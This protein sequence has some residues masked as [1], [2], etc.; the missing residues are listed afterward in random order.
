[1]GRKRPP[2]AVAAIVAAAAHQL[3]V[4]GQAT[5]TAGVLHRI[6]LRLTGALGVCL[7][8]LRAVPARLLQASVS[9]ELS[10]FQSKAGPSAPMSP[11]PLKTD[12]V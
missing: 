4:V 12:N 10:L 7:V 11:L 5:V 6:F 2:A 8:L 1:M 3:G 9:V